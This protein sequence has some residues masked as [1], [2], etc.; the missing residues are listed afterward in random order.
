MPQ[1]A[2]E[3]PDTEMTGIEHTSTEHT[4]AAHFL[5]AGMWNPEQFLME[6][7][8]MVFSGVTQASYPFGHMPIATPFDQFM[9]IHGHPVFTDADVR[10]MFPTSSQI[11]SMGVAEGSSPPREWPERSQPSPS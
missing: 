10:S 4:T 7:P 5:E 11:E 2:P 6:Q 3:A 9:P 1:D 8:P